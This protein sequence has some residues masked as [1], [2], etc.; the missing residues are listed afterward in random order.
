[1]LCGRQRSAARVETSSIPIANVRV[2]IQG[3]PKENWGIV[4]MLAKDLGC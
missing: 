3:E 2:W 4:G 1:M